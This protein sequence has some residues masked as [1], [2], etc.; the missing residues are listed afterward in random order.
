MQI[1]CPHCTTSYAIDPA[2]FGPDGRTVRCARCHET[3]VARPEE[4]AVTAPAHAGRP[5]A[6]Q[7]EPAWDQ[8]PAQ[9][10]WQDH[11]TP[12]IDSPP[13]SGDWGISGDERIGGSLVSNDGW[14]DEPTPA[15]THR[16]LSGLGRSVRLPRGMH[17]PSRLTPFLHARLPRH[18]TNKIT[19]SRACAVMG[20]MVFALVV[21]RAEVVRLMPQT[22][23]F[24]KMIG[25]GVNLRGL[26]FEDVKIA[27]ETVNGKPVLV[28]EGTI[29]SE[30]RKPV[31]LSRLRFSVLDGQGSDIY[32]WNSVLEQSLL[33]PGEKLR[34]KSRLAS[35]PAEGREIAV[36][37]FQRRDIVAGG[38]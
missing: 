13:I 9:N 31:E 15:G 23:A 24:F 36:R 33:N 30:N 1:I 16:W 29:A 17:L 27:T 5:H 35:P 10:G 18:L 4:M 7:S 6:R 3:W 2:K 19:L 34:F 28:I 37:F 26:T 11:D 8:E 21:W 12:H 32:A 14:A 22:A 20:V 38:V 25:M